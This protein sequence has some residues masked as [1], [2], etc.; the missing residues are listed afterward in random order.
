M[1]IEI[2]QVFEITNNFKESR[3]I[4][5][6]INAFVGSK[7]ITFFM[8]IGDDFDVS[9]LVPVKKKVVLDYLEAL[10]SNHNEMK[11]YDWISKIN[12]KITIDLRHTICFV[13]ASRE[14]LRVSKGEE[15]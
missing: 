11:E 5:K 3:E 6:K 7:E 10:E 13:K 8:R 2:E 12:T 14:V 4:V 1:N 9:V 15:E